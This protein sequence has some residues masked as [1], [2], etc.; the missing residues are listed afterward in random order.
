MGEFLGWCIVVSYVLA[1]LNFAFKRINKYYISKLPNKQENIKKQFRV[2]MK[3]FIKYHR[4]FGLL[5][6]LA[7]TIHFIY[8]YLNY[9]ISPTGVIAAITMVILVS[10][11]LFGYLIKK[12][13]K[14]TWLVL[15]R[16]VAFLMIFAIA[17]HIARR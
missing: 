17:L 4:Y 11:G 13:K 8:I 9:W 15:H 5:A 7:L 14:G 12:G 10:L 2:V 3:P 6:I 1:M 16:V